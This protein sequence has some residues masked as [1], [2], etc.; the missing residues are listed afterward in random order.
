MVRVWKAVV[1][2]PVRKSNDFQQA[3][4]TQFVDSA[5]R[6]RVFSKSV[7]GHFSQRALLFGQVAP[8]SVA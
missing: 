7:L 3:E 5:P 1:G 8:L 2:K 4:S 6:A